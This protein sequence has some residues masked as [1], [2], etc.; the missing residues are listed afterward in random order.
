[1]LR[2]MQSGGEVVPERF[3]HV[4]GAK[5]IEEAA[6]IAIHPESNGVTM[7]LGVLVHSV[8]VCIREIT[9][10]CLEFLAHFFVPKT[11]CI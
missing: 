1:M 11:C 10:A 4:P 3:S 2:I 5:S 9:R 6:R 7:C 8:Q